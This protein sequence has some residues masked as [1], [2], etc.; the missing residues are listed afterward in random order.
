V[1]EAYIGVPTGLQT[2]V[3]KQSARQNPISDAKYPAQRRARGKHIT[4]TRAPTTIHFLEP[5]NLEL[6]LEINMASRSKNE[7]SA[8][9]TGYT[10]SNFRATVGYASSNRDARYRYYEPI[11]V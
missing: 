6:L 3:L 2:G 7:Y 1:W 4:R 9:Q 11:F 5:Q 10:S 8:L